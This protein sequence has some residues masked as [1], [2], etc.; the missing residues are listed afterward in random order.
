M[1]SANATSLWSLAL[2]SYPSWILDKHN[3]K[4]L[5]ITLWTVILGR[6]NSKL[7]RFFGVPYTDCLMHSTISLNVHGLPV[8]FCFSALPISLNWVNHITDLSAVACV[9]HGR[10]KLFWRVT[11]DLNSAYHSRHRALCRMDAISLTEWLGPN[12]WREYH[13]TIQC[14]NECDTVLHKTGEDK[15][16]S[17]PI[18]TSWSH[19]TNLLIYYIMKSWNSCSTMLYIWNH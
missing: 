1:K 10:Q 5:C 14:I 3:L 2:F 4:C 18:Q 15:I 12:M 8:V 7:I 11:S 19:D 6:P 17:I 9:P 16:Q 13:S